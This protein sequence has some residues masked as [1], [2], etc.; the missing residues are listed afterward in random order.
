[1]NI[2][3]NKLLDRLARSDKD[4]NDTDNNILYRFLGKGG[5]GTVYL[6]SFEG[7][8]RAV[9]IYKNAHLDQII[10][11]FYITGLLQ[12]MDKVNF[13]IIKMYHYYL[14]FSRPVMVMEIMSGTLSD[15]TKTII[16]N[17]IISTS[18]IDMYWVSMIFQVTY[19]LMT[20]NTYNI[21]HNDAKPKNILFKNNKQNELREYILPNG[22]KYSVPVP[23]IFKISDFSKAQIIGSK[24][25]NMTDQTIKT[26]IL[27][28][29][30][31]Y[32]LS[33]IL[34]RILV[35]YL[36]L[37]YKLSDIQN[38]MD[39]QMQD[40]YR[41]MNDQFKSLPEKIRNRL[42]LRG[43]IYYLIDHQ[44]INT[45]ELIKKHNLIFPSKSVQELLRNLH[46]VTDYPDIYGLFD[47]YFS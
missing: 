37:D 15:W 1:M 23:Y 12:E 16:N 24:L 19:S 45:Q 32:E 13:N 26:N 18:E 21:L 28:R 6:I 47:N 34:D 36:I 11:E 14:S 3:N 25:N 27:N 30:D 40:V 38:M 43:M 8:E 7:D 44:M 29:Y 31:I 42:L 4:Y 2:F 22:K 46:N 35:D 10:K 20:I 17:K 39:K 9:K 5:D 41:K 33:H